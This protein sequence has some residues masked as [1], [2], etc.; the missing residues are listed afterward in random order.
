ML[1][2]EFLFDKRLSD[3]MIK[4]GLVTREEYEEYLRGLPDAAPKG[5]TLA[6]GPGEE[7]PDREA[8]RTP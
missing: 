7:P 5:E 6:V 1:R 4:R 3:R 8:S 2:E